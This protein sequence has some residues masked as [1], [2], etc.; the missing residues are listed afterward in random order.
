M[1][2]IDEFDPFEACFW[3]FF[4]VSV[5]CSFCSRINLSLLLKH[6]SSKDYP[7]P[8]GVLVNV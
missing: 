8:S 3:A 6:D 4:R 2:L 7:V 1:L 5:Q